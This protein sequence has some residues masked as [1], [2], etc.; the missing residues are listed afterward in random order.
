M[1]IGI[2]DYQAGNIASL[3]NAIEYLGH[4]PVVIDKPASIKDFIHI[5]LP[6]VGAFGHGVELL[7]SHG[8]DIAIKDFIQEK[9]GYFLGICLGMQLMCDSSDEEGLN[10]GLGLVSGDVRRLVPLNSEE[11]IP[12]VGWNSVKIDVLSPITEGI[13]SNSDF[14]FVHS[15]GLQNLGQQ[16]YI[17]G[18][19]EFAQGFASIVKCGDLAYGVQFHPEKSSKHGLRLLKNFLEFS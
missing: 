19:T 7:R 3:A 17:L 5:I 2:I 10:P 9:N 15:Y 18:T 14:Y 16:E 13:P 12:H 8:W 11:K 4:Q 6:G 1:K